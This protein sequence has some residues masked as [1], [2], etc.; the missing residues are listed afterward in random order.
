MQKLKYK[1]DH[2]NALPEHSHSISINGDIIATVHMKVDSSTWA[3]SGFK[4]LH[5]GDGTI[6]T[7]TSDD[8]IRS[9]LGFS[10]DQTSKRIKFDVLQNALKNFDEKNGTSLLNTFNKVRVLQLNSLN[11]TVNATMSINDTGS[12]RISYA[13]DDI[14]ET[15]PTHTILPTMI[16]VGQRKRSY[17]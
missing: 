1:V 14:D 13:G 9:A 16:Y 6:L 4:R 5:G 7:K 3:D 2:K 8:A 12:I 17:L 15:Y 11:I 10:K